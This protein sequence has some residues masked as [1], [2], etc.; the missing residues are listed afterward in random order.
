[1][2]RHKLILLFI[3][4]NLLHTTRA[5][6]STWTKQ[7]KEYYAKTKE[8]C[9]YLKA[10]P[11][12]TSKRQFI[13]SNFIRFV[14]PKNDTS[15]SRL[16]YFDMLFYHF[17]H[18]VDSVGLENLDARP[19]RFFKNDAA[20]Y[21]PFTE[22]LKWT[23]SSSLVLAYYDKRE[24]AKPLGALLYDPESRKLFSWIILNMGGYLF[25]TP[26]MY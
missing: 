8:L 21:K 18:F 13:F 22:E 14:N 23:D 16:R 26:N 15:Q 1:M 25:L 17:Y 19:V 24:P 10:T 3:F 2:N 9:N 12:D 5:Q 4:V 6:N 11:Y 20:F 7:E